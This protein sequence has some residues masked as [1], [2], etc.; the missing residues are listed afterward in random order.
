MS[1][2]GGRR[3][4]IIS[5]DDLLE[6][7]IGE[8]TL[9][10]E[11]FML[12]EKCVSL[13]QHR[14]IVVSGTPSSAPTMPSRFSAHPSSGKRVSKAGNVW[15]RP[16]EFQRFER[17]AAIERLE[18]LEQVFYTNMTRGQRSLCAWLASWR[19]P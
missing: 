15:N 7:A 3:G 2:E 18:R 1:G 12:A 6:A 11:T 4:V 9:P 17:S 5:S 13:L 14:R 10:V 8:C 19:M 16:G